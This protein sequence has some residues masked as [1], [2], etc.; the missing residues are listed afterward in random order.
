MYNAIS[1][2]E[3]AMRIFPE[4]LNCHNC[5]YENENESFLQETRKLHLNDNV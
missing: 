5:F 2:E 3:L 4:I 1:Y